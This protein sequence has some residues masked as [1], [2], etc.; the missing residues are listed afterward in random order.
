MNPAEILELSYRI[1]LGEAFAALVFPWLV[2]VLWRRW[3]PRWPQTFLAAAITIAVMAP[4]YGFTASLGGDAH[5]TVAVLGN[6]VGFLVIWM[7]R[8][9]TPA[10][11]DQPAKVP[12]A[13]WKLLLALLGSLASLSLISVLLHFGPG[14]SRSSLAEAGIREVAPPSYETD[15]KNALESR[16]AWAAYAAYREAARHRDTQKLRPVIHASWRPF[17]LDGET[18]TA[19]GLGRAITCPP[20]LEVVVG[21]KDQGFD[22][23]G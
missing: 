5:A 16:D 13:R 10:R 14:A 6:V 22:M 18:L 11:R 4:V 9:R 23:A 1:Y 17:G 20:A 8:D 2:L 12:D 7:L 21:Q 3:L 19:V 15:F